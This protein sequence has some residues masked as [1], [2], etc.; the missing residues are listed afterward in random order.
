MSDALDRRD[1]LR[2]ASA[3]GLGLAIAPDAAL[4]ASGAASDAPPRPQLDAADS[5][6]AAAP[7]EVVRIG[8]VG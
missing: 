4:A 3:A 8:V 2:A 5:V 6:L 1:F 7:M